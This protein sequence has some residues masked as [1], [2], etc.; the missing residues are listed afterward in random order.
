MDEPQ[1]IQDLKAFRGYDDA[2]VYA[3][4]LVA[5]WRASWAKRN[6]TDAF[7]GY[8]RFGPATWHEELWAAWYPSLVRQFTFGTGKG[9]RKRYGAC[10]YTAD[11]YDPV[12]CCLYEIDGPSHRQSDRRKADRRRDAFFR[13]RGIDV[14]RIS[15]DEVD[16]RAIA[17]LTFALMFIA[18]QLGAPTALELSEEERN[19]ARPLI[20]LLSKTAILPSAPDTMSAWIV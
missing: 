1:L 15:T 19:K 20:S 6:E 9:G 18:G 13:E 11:F 14:V 12:G 3:E 4:R 5:L 17:S 2:R 7:A 16:R 8:R 10:S